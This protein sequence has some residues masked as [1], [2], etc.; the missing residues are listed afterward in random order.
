[1]RERPR[2]LVRRIRGSEWEAYRAIRLAALSDAPDAFA[3][4]YDAEENRPDHEWQQRAEA[5]ATSDG[6]TLFV[7][8]DDDDGWQGMAGGYSPGEPPAD[9]ELISMWLAPA[10]RGTGQGAALVD[11]VVSWARDRGA[12]TIGLWVTDGN[13]PAQ[14]LYER[15]GFVATGDRQPL[16]S[17][18]AKTELRM[19]LVTS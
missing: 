10:C 11:A 13:Q 9:V 3:S 7:L 14:R 1:M 12:R 6:S 5:N 16:P 15:C 2:V 4:T 18:P 17:D 8:V 19:L